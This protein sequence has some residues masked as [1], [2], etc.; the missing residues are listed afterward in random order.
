MSN[1]AITTNDL[2][3]VLDVVLPPTPSEYKKLLWT[4]PSPTSSFAAQTIIVPDISEYDDLEMVTRGGSITTGNTF[5]YPVAQLL[6]GNVHWLSFIGQGA[7]GLPSVNGRPF[8]VVSSTQIHFE[9]GGYWNTA[10]NSSGLA[11]AGVPL[12]IYGIKYERVNP[13]QAEIAD[14][15][16]EQGANAN[17]S[18][19]KWESGTMEQWGVEASASAS[20]HSVNFPTSFK[21]AAYIVLGTNT[22]GTQS[23]FMTSNTSSSSFMV[24]VTASTKLY[25]I[26][27]GKW[28]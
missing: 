26:A 10:G 2:K 18:Y 1:K 8:N 14:V 27:I 19:R 25:W 9:L 24:Y 23:N 22:S 17:G 5:K 12:K 13:P 6:E 28:K 16:V 21:D 4:N 15:V 7:T 11:T 3:A 20:N